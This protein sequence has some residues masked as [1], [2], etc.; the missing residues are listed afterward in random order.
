MDDRQ[1]MVD[2][3]SRS[4]YYII[5]TRLLDNNITMTCTIFYCK[6]DAHIIRFVS[7]RIATR[8]FIKLVRAQSCLCNK[9]TISVLHVHAV[10][11]VYNKMLHKK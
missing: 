5:L 9:V 6:L 1:F 11:V 8:N 3:S 2:E 10:G 4:L 7:T